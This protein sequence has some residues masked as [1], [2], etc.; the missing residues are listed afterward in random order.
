MECILHGLQWKSALIYLDDVIVYWNN[1]EQELER[2][3]V[4]FKCFK[5]INLK[6]NTKK[7]V[8]FQTKVPF[9]GQIV[10]RHGEKI[11]PEK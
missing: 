5:Q 10:S 2:L 9:L 6:L 1:F 4:L 3:E 7:C 11:N 8:F